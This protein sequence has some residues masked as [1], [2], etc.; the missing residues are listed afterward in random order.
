MLN[1]IL[2]FAAIAAGGALLARQLRKSGSTGMQSSARESIEV[3][4]PV[5]ATYDQWTQF[6]DFPQFMNSVHEVRQLDTRHLHWRADVF[7][8]PAEWEAEIT[9]QIPDRKIAWRSIS[10]TPNGGVVT[11]AALSPSRTKIT[12]EMFY[13]P[14]GALEAVGDA[15]GTVR[16]EVRRN[17]QQFK[18]NLEQRGHETGAWRGALPQQPAGQAH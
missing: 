10:G 13:T 7:G 11:F 1:R 15:L 9:E 17:L 16:M 18:E 2:M 8:K 4:L 5:R 14:Q 12:L 6:E 3:D